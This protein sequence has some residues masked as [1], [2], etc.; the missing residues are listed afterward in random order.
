MRNELVAM[1]EA[2]KPIDRRRLDAVLRQRLAT[3]LDDLLAHQL[4]QIRR[5]RDR[6]SIRLDS[7]YY[8]VKEHVETIWDDPARADDCCVLQ[9]MLA[10]YESRVRKRRQGQS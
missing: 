2:V 9:E 10:A 8:V 5:I 4:G 3:S 1:I 7:E 6:R